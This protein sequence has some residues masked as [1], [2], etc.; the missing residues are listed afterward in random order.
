MN[1]LFYGWYYIKYINYVIKFFKFG[2]KF[3]VILLV[4]VWYDYGLLFDLGK[5]DDLFVGSFFEVGINW[6]IGVWL[7]YK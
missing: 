4:G 3:V 5:W 6:L 7:F 2:G 1:L